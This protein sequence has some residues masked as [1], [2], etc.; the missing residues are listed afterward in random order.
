MIHT[1]V[2]RILNANG[3]GAI[4]GLL[5][6]YYPVR[7]NGTIMTAYLQYYLKNIRPEV[8]VLVESR[9]IDKVYRDIFSYYLTTK[10]KLYGMYCVKLSFFEPEVDLNKIVDSE[11]TVEKAIKGY[12]GFMV[13]RPIYP[14]TIGRTVLNP[15]AFKHGGDIQIC[16]CT[17]R[18]SAYGLQMWAKGFPHS[19]Q[20]SQY[21][22]CAETSIWSLVEYYGNKYPE[23]SPV[24]PSRVHDILKEIKFDRDV[25]SDG[26]NF[27]D[28]SKVLKSI[29]FGCKTYGLTFGP[30]GKVS[31]ESKEYLHRMMAVYIESGIPFVVALNGVDMDGENFG[32]AVVC[33]G[34]G[35]QPRN[36]IKSATPS[37]LIPAVTGVKNHQYYHWADVRRSFVFNDD[38]TSDYAMVAYDDP[39]SQYG[40]NSGVIVNIIVPLYRKIYLDADSALTL[41]EVQCNNIL[42]VS[43]NAVLR[44]YLV[45]AN[46]YI[47]S[48]A[49]DPKLDTM[50]KKFLIEKFCYPHF[51]WVTEISSAEEFEKDILSG[52]VLLDAT[53]PL[54]DT[55]TTSV[56]LSIYD[57]KMNYYDWDTQ[58]IQEISLSLPFEKTTYRNLR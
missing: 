51:I 1:T 43:D 3:A 19:S 10:S 24:L 53:E 45:S 31:A 25:P 38:N 20:D 28:V 37:S 55:E 36:T 33:V 52:L 57:G 14:G 9:Y 40:N 2:D 39:C 22:T 47:D 44:T 49:R 58:T 12:L 30:S 4:I 56:I 34:E 32:H 42:N 48:V 11:A 54:A 16:Q 6:Q 27:Y 13:V 8:K 5:G 35:K 18:T 41:A 46:S 23:Y 15:K 29:G 7:I 17:I 26:L 21:L 50:W